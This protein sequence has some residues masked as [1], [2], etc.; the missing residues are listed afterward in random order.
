LLLLFVVDLGLFDCCS[1]VRCTFTF[2]D[3][4]VTFVLYVVTDLDVRYVCIRFLVCDLFMFIVVAT[5]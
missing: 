3:A 2:V 1:F 4:F 5:L